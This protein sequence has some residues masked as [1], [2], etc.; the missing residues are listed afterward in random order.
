[1]FVGMII[2]FVAHNLVRFVFSK[3]NK[4]GNLMLLP[5]LLL[6][7]KHTFSIPYYMQHVFL[8]K[9]KIEVAGEQIWVWTRP[10]FLLEML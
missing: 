10:A 4:G 5:M 6:M 1:M 2:V 7:Y 8:K 9:K 3:L